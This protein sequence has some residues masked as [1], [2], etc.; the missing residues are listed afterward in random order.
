MQRSCIVHT[1]KNH[2]KVVTIHMF[3]NVP[4][5]LRLVPS[6]L[7]E[8]VGVVSRHAT[9]FERSLVQLW[10]GHNLVQFVPVSRGRV[11]HLGPG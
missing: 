5:E 4:D 6:L 11:P 3:L 2:C 7:D 9:F 8:V 1:K 10:H